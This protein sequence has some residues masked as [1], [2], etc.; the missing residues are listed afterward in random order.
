MTQVSQT[1][2]NKLEQSILRDAVPA[3]VLV[4]ADVVVFCWQTKLI[5][6]RKP[7]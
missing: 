7:A 6:P 4:A 3:L 5:T 2:S 1:I